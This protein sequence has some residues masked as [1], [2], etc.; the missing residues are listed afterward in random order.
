M[1][2][3]AKKSPAHFAEYFLVNLKANSNANRAANKECAYGE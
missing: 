3:L 2:E 1:S